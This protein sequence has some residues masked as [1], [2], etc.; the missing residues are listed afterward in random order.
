MPERIKARLKM[1]KEMSSDTAFFTYRIGMK[2]LVRVRCDYQIRLNYSW[3][4]YYEIVYIYY[5]EIHI[6]DL[7]MAISEAKKFLSTFPRGYLV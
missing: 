3:L 2:A 7:G 4:L 5:G 1:A 6:F